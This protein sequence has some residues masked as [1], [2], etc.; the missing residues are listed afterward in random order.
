[1]TR[2]KRMLVL[3]AV[4][5][6]ACLA[7]S[8]TAQAAGEVGVPVIIDAFGNPNFAAGPFTRSVIPLP[9][10]GTSIG[11]PQ[12]TFSQS[13]AVAT[14]KMSG[15]G[16]GISGTTLQY[17]PTSGAPVDL[18]GG[19]TDAQIFI[20]FALIDQVPAPGD[21]SVPGATTFIS[22]TDA[23]GNVATSPSDAVGNFFAFNAAFP[24][25]GFQTPTGFD[26]TKVTQLDISFVYPSGN[27]GG[28]SLE[29]QVN[30]LWATPESGSPPSPPSPT[31]TGPS[32]TGCGSV[33]FTVSFTSNEGAAP[34]TFD[35]PSDIGVRA[36][37]LTVAGT[38]FGARRQRSTSA[39]DHRHIRSPSRV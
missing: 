29:V 25:T 33:D 17:V 5:L 15:A 30:K 1:M 20:D 31:V 13:N 18:T 24:F 19:G 14:M 3:L 4:T 9:T 21:L 32:V 16:T 22:A 12:G 2:L 35:P 36:Q 7:I 28:G 39:A 6:T 26:F 11:T 10:P 23:N 38:A 34:V 8:A 27:T 37:D